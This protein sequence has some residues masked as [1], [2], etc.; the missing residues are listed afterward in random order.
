MVTVS[1]EVPAETEARLRG[2]F[3]RC[4]V[5][6]LPGEWAFVEG[7]PAT[8]R[9]DS[10][11]DVRVDGQLSA[12]CPAG[13]TGAERFNLFRVVLP[14]GEDDSG[15]VGWLCSR[16]KAATGSGLFVVCGHN[17]SLGGVYDYYGVPR[18]AAGAV[19]TLLDRLRGRDSLDGAVLRLTQPADNATVGPG[20]VM[21]IEL[22][23][24][25][26]RGHYGGGAIQ[27]GWL[28][29][30]IQADGSTARFNFLQ[31]TRDGLVETGVSTARIRRLTDGRWR[32][33]EEFAWTSRAGSGTN[34]FEETG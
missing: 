12:L 2:V 29:G 33:T 11:A 31:L 10:I 13:D 27:D 4:A 21:C 17:Q 34:V 22:D 23:G 5:D 20:T 24:N 30:T 15:F 26:L 19:R 25:T 18:S 7:P 3:R 14:A 9:P 16:I 32:L 1:V 28:I 8:G 6:W